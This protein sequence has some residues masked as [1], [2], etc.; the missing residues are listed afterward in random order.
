MWASCHWD[1]QRRD[2]AGCVD[3]RRA[4]CAGGCNDVAKSL[5]AV[6]VVVGRAAVDTDESRTW[7]ASEACRR[8]ST[9]EK[10]DSGYMSAG[11]LC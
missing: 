6:V 4:G 1:G 10:R 5:I 9:C 7:Q 11:I 2:G 8:R 3:W